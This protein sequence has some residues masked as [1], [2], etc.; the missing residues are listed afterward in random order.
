MAPE[1]DDAVDSCVEVL[2]ISFLA[3]IALRLGIPRC[4]M[5]LRRWE[6]DLQ[7]VIAGYV[8]SHF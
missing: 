4:A 3:S 2:N 8:L 5:A 7:Y 6:V 1:S